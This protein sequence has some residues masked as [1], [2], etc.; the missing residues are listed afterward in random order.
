MAN[1]ASHDAPA[2]SE[3][4]STR[5]QSSVVVRMDVCNSARGIGPSSPMVMT[6]FAS[7]ASGSKGNLG[8]KAVSESYRFPRSLDA[9]PAS[10]E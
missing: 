3:A 7:K 10:W 8:I 1:T 6:R 5:E 9:R 2:S 4:D